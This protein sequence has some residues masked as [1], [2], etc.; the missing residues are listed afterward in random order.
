MS[1]R[2]AW[3]IQELISL[4]WLKISLKTLLLAIELVLQY[5][6]KSSV[7]SHVAA[8]RKNSIAAFVRRLSETVSCRFLGSGGE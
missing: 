5:L 6:D 7:G 8:V 2:Q 3:R 4:V 1:L